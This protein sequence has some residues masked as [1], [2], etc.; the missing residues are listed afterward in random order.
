MKRPL[1]I[2]A[3]VTAGLLLLGAPFLGVR[4]SQPDDRVLPE[5][6]PAREVSERLRADFSSRETN[7]FA[8][9]TA[10]DEPVAGGDVAA[11]AATL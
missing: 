11:A 7:A 1:P 3:V 4:F 5:G 8:V 2:A 9:I 10:S 6:N